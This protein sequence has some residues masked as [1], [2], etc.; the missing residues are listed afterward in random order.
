MQVIES[1]FL[2]SFPR[3][4]IAA[5]CTGYSLVTKTDTQGRRIQLFQE[6]EFFH[7]ALPA[8]LIPGK[9]VRATGNNDGAGIGKVPVIGIRPADGRRFESMAV[10]DQADI[11]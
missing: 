6:F 4:N 10:D 8:L 11:G 9:Q 5:K 7:N 2:L 1:V 3:V